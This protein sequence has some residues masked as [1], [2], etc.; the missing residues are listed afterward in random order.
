MP[1]TQ[2]TRKAISEDVNRTGSETVHLSPYSGG[3][4]N[5]WRCTSILVWFILLWCL[6]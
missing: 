4:K 2:W 6:I 1:N 3:A 5:V